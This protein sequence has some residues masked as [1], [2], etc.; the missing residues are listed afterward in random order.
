MATSTQRRSFEEMERIRIN[1][2]LSK[3]HS[4]A[5]LMDRSSEILAF[6]FTINLCEDLLLKTLFHKSMWT[7]VMLVGG[8]NTTDEREGFL[9]RPYESEPS[10]DI[11]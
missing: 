7:E 8:F 4:G 5:R 6:M 10:L 2:A 3:A 1:D 11:W 9:R